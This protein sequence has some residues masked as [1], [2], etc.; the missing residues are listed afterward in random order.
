MRRVSDAP[1]DSRP[2][3]DPLRPFAGRRVVLGVSGGADSVAMWRALLEVGAV[4]TAAHL[5]HA[6][7]PDS[8]D[9]AAWV[10]ALGEALGAP[11]A[12][13]RADVARVAAA[14]GWNVEAAARTLRYAFLARAAKRAGAEAV[15]TA[16]TLDDQA[17]TVLH[18]LLRGDHDL[19][20]I[21]AARGRV[22][23]PWLGVRR[24]DPRAYLIGLRQGWREDPTNADPRFTRNWLRAE[25]LPLA[26]S[27]FPAVDGALARR[28]RLA[29]EDEAVLGALAAAVP[30]HAD[31][32]REA[33]AVRRRFVAARLRAA[34]LSFRAEHVDLLADALGAG[35][36]VHARLPG[37]VDVTVTGGALHLFPREGAP[38]EG[39]RPDFAVPPP[40]VVR[41][42]APGDRVRL[43]GGTRK[44][45]DV[46][47]D[48]KVPRAD[49]DRLWVVARGADVRWIG[50]DPPLFAE[51]AADELG[52]IAPPAPWTS[53]M[54]AAL[55]LARR[56]AAGGE[57][58]VGAV[59][60]RAGEIVAGAHNTSRAAGDLTRHAELDALRLAAAALGTPYLTDCTLVVTLEPCPMCFGALVE[61][62]VARVVF[63]ADNPKL[64][65]LGGVGDLSRFAWGH[66]PEVV[67]GV[68]AREAGEV[69]RA[70]FAGRREG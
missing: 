22:R 44:L 16:H 69:L 1:F 62:R 63:G 50:L 12:V 7:R 25:V 29:A 26:R 38:R 19:R 55:D 13:E 28:A 61:A 15:L 65:A 32:A 58:P 20:G 39:P 45:S 70:F 27:R 21:A 47:T 33:P 42:R 57:V 67:R 18:A 24:A 49:R 54:G 10:R 8:A 36:T 68:R 30:G 60:V 51:G 52:V 17:E 23:R 41:R 35:G 9:D 53:E 43:P 40:L 64:G 31:P 5:D 4:V 37:G 48:R 6:L 34:G 11:V 14:R 66:R 2:L 59:V 3:L 46:L 56:A